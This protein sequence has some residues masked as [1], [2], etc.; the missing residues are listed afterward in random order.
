MCNLFYFCYHA[1][2][3]LMLLLAFRAAVERE[4][5]GVAE[6]LEQGKMMESKLI[7][8]AREVEKLRAELANAQKRAYAASAIGNPGILCCK[9]MLLVPLGILYILFIVYSL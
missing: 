7:T 8:M 5:K 3:I 1:F 4:K 9:L 2:Y 6:S